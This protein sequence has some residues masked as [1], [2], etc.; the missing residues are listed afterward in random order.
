[1]L[2]GR[3]VGVRADAG[4]VADLGV[5]ADGVLDDAVRRRR[6][7]RSRR[8]SGPISQPSPTTVSPCR[9]VPGI[10]RDVAAELDGDVDERLARVEHRDAV[11]QPVA[12]GAGAQLAL[13]E[14]Q[15][16][17]VVDALGLVGGRL[18]AADAV[19][20]A[21]EH[22]DDVGEVVLALGVVGRQVAQRRAEQV[23]AEGVDARVDLVDRELV[24][25]GVALL[26]DAQHAPVAV[27]RTT[28][29]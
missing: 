18:H 17:A 10:Q 2:P 29:P 28:R 4:A 5:A 22:A 14:G 23:A 6:R 13:G 16:P 21:G 20:H 7:S 26:D 24:G 12:V 3:Q 27:P 1:M 11:E 8:V 19:A 9:I 15:L 25:R